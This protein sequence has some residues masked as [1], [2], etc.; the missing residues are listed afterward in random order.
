MLPSR[1]RIPPS[2]LGVAPERAPV[3]QLDRALVYETKGR[4]F[5]S[6][7]A[8]LTEKPRF[9]R[10]FSVWARPHSRERS[11]TAVLRATELGKRYGRR[12]AL[13]D[14]TFEIPAGRVVG[15]VGPN[16]AG[17]TTLLHLAVGLLAPTSGSIE[18]LGLRPAASRAQLGRVG[19]VAQETP[20]YPTLSVGDH[21]R[22]GAW[23]N[24]GWNRDLAE[25]RV[26][27]PRSR[28]VPKDRQTLRRPA[29]STRPHHGVRQAPRAPDPR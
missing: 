16:G 17:K 18:V 29:S 10:G 14:C 11:V 9:W 12:W 8:H 3:A 5:E 24:P 13:R 23:L 25:D 7:P 21:L 2:P 15:L 26:E 19:F 22:L 20:T 27:R 28:S 1:V 4:R 6:F